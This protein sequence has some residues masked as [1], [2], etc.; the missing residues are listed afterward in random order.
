[1]K[2]SKYI[3]GLILVLIIM[4]SMTA[5]MS[6]NRNMFFEENDEE[7]GN[8]IED[9]EEN[10]TK[11]SKTENIENE[12]VVEDNIESSEEDTT[13]NQEDVVEDRDKNIYTKVFDE[14]SPNDSYKNI[15]VFMV[16]STTGMLY[17]DTKSKG[18]MIFSINERTEEI[19]LV[20]V[21][22]MTYWNIDENSKYGQAKYGYYYGPEVALGMLN[23][24]MDLAI[25]DFITIGFEGM[26]KLVDDIGGVDAYIDMD[27]LEMMNDR[28]YTKYLPDEMEENME[29]LPDIGIQNLDGT[30][31][32]AYCMG[33]LRGLD[34]SYYVAERQQEIVNNMALNLMTMDK[35]FV[36]YTFDDLYTK[37]LY[38]SLDKEEYQELVNL[39]RVSGISKNVIFPS[40]ELS[41]SKVLG[42]NGTSLWPTDLAQSVALVHQ[43]LFSKDNYQPT[44][45]V[46]SIAEEIKKKVAEY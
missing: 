33:N 36:S 15:A 32:L 34:N 41:E 44:Q 18:I 17:S 7:G 28:Q 46:Q 2:K 27:E 16:D 43:F 14:P 26:E 21:Q 42:S 20:N 5:C 1:M 30:Q 25:T 13:L 29:L 19:K 22:Y 37:Y 23:R 31:A 24:N 3:K 11:E 8:V 6:K 9:E 45:T 12:L 38:T 4:I 10:V 40:S 39:I 35:D